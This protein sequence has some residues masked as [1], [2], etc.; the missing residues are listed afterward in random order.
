[1]GRDEI[2]RY[3]YYRVGYHRGL[4]TLR[5]NGW[6]GSGYVRWADADQPGV[7]ACPRRAAGRW[8]RRSASDDEAER[9]ALFLP[10]STR[11]LPPDVVM[12]AVPRSADMSAARRRCLGTSK[13]ATVPV[14][15]ID[16]ERARPSASSRWLGW[17][18]CASP[19][20]TTDG[21]VPGAVLVPLATVPDHVDA[22][23]G[24]GPTYVICRSGARS[25]R[26]CE[27]LAALR[28]ADVEVV[29][30]AGGTMAWMA[31]GRETVGGDQP[32][33]T[34]RW[35][36]TPGRSRRRHRRAGRPS[37]AYAIDTEFHRE[38]TYFPRLALVQLAWPTA[39]TRAGRPAGRRPAAAAPSC[40]RADAS[41]WS[42]PPS[43]TSTCSPTP[44]GAVPAHLFDTQVAA[45]FVGY[46]TPSLVSLLQGELGVSR[47]RAT[48]SPTGCAGR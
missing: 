23:A 46:G 19:T 34:D 20:S 33:V 6:R 18:M 7:P 45:G 28:L 5:A 11:R 36:D 3:A 40:S 42:T 14:Q 37:P 32:C 48:A 1:M 26:A 30:V 38:R 8:R 39:S 4:D 35:I 29:N 24:D 22:F 13:L 17:S 25:M 12:P 16:V 44:C 27:Y 10:S 31:S 21:H 41:P 9:I 47:P 15:E 43:R 2:E